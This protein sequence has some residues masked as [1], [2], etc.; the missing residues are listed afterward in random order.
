[1]TANNYTSFEDIQRAGKVVPFSVVRDILSQT[2][3]VVEHI[4]ETNGSSK[5]RVTVP[6][7]WN[8]GLKELD[9]TNLTT[10]TI[11]FQGGGEYTL[12]KRA[13][14]T[15]LHLIGISDRYA[16]KSPGHLIEPQINYW[17]K[18]EGVG[19]SSAIKLVTKDS[20]AVAFMS[21]KSP[22][23]SNLE[24]LEQIRKYFKESRTNPRLYVDP[25]IV[26]TYMETD[27][28]IILP[29][30]QFEVVA[31]RNGV[32][33]TDRWHYG[34]HV[35]NSL[36][37]YAAQPLTISG[38]MV[39][40]RNLT[41][42]L[43]EYSQT[44][45]YVRNTM[46]DMDDVRGWVSST[47]S[48]VLAILPSESDL[49]QHAATHTLQGKVGTITTDIFRTMK[50]HRKVQEVTLDILTERGDMTAYGLMVALAGAVAPTSPVTFSPKIVNHVQRVA[51]ALP[52]RAED[53]CNGCGR[54]HL[55]D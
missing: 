14:L 32:K 37:A 27:F 49:I 51:G 20:Y 36:M 19:T 7:D 34:V 45:N 39:E 28:R 5:V 13:M 4:L 8:L 9:D 42:I 41:G 15:L 40:Q 47:L 11:S 6:D 38:F 29:Q 3:P 18:H 17:F 12:I 16:F 43:P 26:N 33:E 1:M 25:N 22:V 44:N 2:E 24:V 30:V 50:I 46:L 35:T 10:A 21:V 53:I 52:M 31:E 48:Q 54:I 23:I 55:Q